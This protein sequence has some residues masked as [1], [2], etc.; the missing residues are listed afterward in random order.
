MKRR[1]YFFAKRAFDITAALV[2][3]IGTSPI[4]IAAMIG[5]LISDPGPLFYKAR[6][7]GKDNEEFAM[8]KFRSMRVPRNKTEASEAS[9]KADTDRIFPFGHLCRRLKID[10]LPQLLNIL[11]GSMSVVGPRPAAKDQVAIVRAGRYSAAAAVRPGLTSPA[12]LYDY[13]YG[14][15]VED[16][17]EYERLV[18][19]TRLELEAYYPTHM[20]AGYDIKLIWYTVVCIFCKLLHRFP[21]KIFDEI[22]G[23]VQTAD[24]A[25]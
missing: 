11:D 9:F 8:W 20:S 2:G 7:V 10:E 14:D 1:A 17:E 5:I 21:Q 16:P 25:N 3:I 13:L 4:W 22:V 18:L 12:A 24:A 15:D 23:S 6:R 19:P